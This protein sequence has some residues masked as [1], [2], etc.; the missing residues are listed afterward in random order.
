MVSKTESA[1][2]SEIQ[3]LPVV[4]PKYLMEKREETEAG[5]NV[6]FSLFNCFEKQNTCSNRNIERSDTS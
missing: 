3:K 6:Q 1:F 4:I 2:N 5:L